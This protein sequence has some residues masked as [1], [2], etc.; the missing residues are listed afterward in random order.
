M[1]AFQE[2]CFGAGHPYA[3]PYTGSG[4]PEALA[5]LD[6]ADLAAFHAAH[7]T[8]DNAVLVVAGALDG[9]TALALARDVFGRWAP[10]ERPAPDVPAAAPAAAGSILVLDRPGA[11]Q[12][13]IVGGFPAVARRDADYTALDVV[14]TAFGGQFGSRINMNLRE[15]KGYTYGVRSQLLAL[16]GGGAFLMSTPVETGVTVAAMRELVRAF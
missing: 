5:A 10:G 3:Q 14:N 1:K 6:V 12:S 11:A 4:D 8:A 9:E 2:R 13:F 7:Y 15:D 16:G